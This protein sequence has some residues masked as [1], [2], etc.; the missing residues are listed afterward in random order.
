MTSMEFEGS[1]KNQ[2]SGA[3]GLVQR[4]PGPGPKGPKGAQ[5][6][7]GAPVQRP[8]KGF[9]GPRGPRGARIRPSRPIPPWLEKPPSKSQPPPDPFR[10]SLS[11]PPPLIPKGG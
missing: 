1:C 11:I 8:P 3:L 7:H 2:W 4:V 6:A 5:G 9:K 10:Q